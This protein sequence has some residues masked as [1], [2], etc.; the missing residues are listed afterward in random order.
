[1]G[2][3]VG[4]L[5]GSKAIDAFAAGAEGLFHEITGIHGGGGEQGDSFQV[6]HGD[7]DNWVMDL[8][9]GGTGAVDRASSSKSDYKLGTPP[10]DGKSKIA[11]ILSPGFVI[12]L[13]RVSCDIGADVES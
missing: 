9:R 3:L 4:R 11:H 7:N 8:P 5:P 2:A 6:L 13:S 10:A 1:M 12:P